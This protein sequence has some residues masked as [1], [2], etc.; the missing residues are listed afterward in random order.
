MFAV[1]VAD[2]CSS[3]LNYVNVLRKN[4]FVGSK[5][6][7]MLYNDNKAAAMIGVEEGSEGNSESQLVMDEELSRKDRNFKGRFLDGN[8]AEVVGMEHEDNK[9]DNNEIVED[10]L[11]RTINEV[12]EVCDLVV[13]VNLPEF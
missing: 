2:L 6:M 1:F 11:E 13:P 9:S 7:E 8:P 3:N 5:G 10:A 12:A 4:N